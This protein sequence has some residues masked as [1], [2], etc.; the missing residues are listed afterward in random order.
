MT[1]N[2]DT[3][4]R[5][6]SRGDEDHAFPV[7][8][9]DHAMGLEL[10]IVELVEQQTRA[11][12]QHRLDDAARLEDEIDELRAELAATVEAAAVG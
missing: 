7:D 1:S 10:Q 5:D 9:A 2:T 6:T 4:W 11:V 8:K 3:V 12:V